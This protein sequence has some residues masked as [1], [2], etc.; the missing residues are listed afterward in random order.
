MNR[1][2]PTFSIREIGK[3]RFYGGVLFG[4]LQSLVVFHFLI[5]II[6]SE[7]TFTTGYYDGWDL[8]FKFEFDSW[9]LYIIALISVSLSFC[10]ITQFWL[11]LSTGQKRSR[12]FKKL[13]ARTQ[14]YFI[15]FFILAALLKVSEDVFLLYLDGFGPYFE[16]E[17][18]L[19]A[20]LLPSYVFLYNWNMIATV[21]QSLKAQLLSIPIWL[22]VSYLISLTY[23]LI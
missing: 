20:I 21:Y 23:Y 10:F 5:S 6:K 11:S 19:I 12:R 14:T 16:Q 2:K 3:V 13:K 9:T 4:L 15:F 8:Y 18:N 1:Y 7:F 22:G 17:Y